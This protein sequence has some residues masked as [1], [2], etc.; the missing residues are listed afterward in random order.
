M[1]VSIAENWHFCVACNE[2][3]VARRFPEVEKTREVVEYMECGP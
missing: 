1:H 2:I 3:V